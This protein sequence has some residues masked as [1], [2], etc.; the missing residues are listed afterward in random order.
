[1][2]YGCC[3]QHSIA[4]R[5]EKL[6]LLSVWCVIFIFFPQLELSVWFILCRIYTYVYSL[7]MYSFAIIESISV[8]QLYLFDTICNLYRNRLLSCLEKKDNIFMQKFWFTVRITLIKCDHFL[9][10][11]PIKQE[12]KPWWMLFWRKKLLLSAELRIIYTLRFLKGMIF[13]CEK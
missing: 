9:H 5:N 8:S 3:W 11:A 6:K 2:H 7:Q 13:F 12:R 10:V 1:M 4:K